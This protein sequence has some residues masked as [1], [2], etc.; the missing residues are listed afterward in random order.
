M[1]RAEYCD[2]DMPIFED[3]VDYYENTTGSYLV[4][5]LAEND[6]FSFYVAN[7]YKDVSATI[8]VY[9]YTEHT[10][11]E[12][13]IPAKLPTPSTTGY[14][15][16]IE[17][18]VCGAIIKAPVEIKVTEEKHNNFKIAS[19]SLTMQENISVNYY[20]IV[21][22]EAG[23]D[24]ENAYIVFLFNGEEFIVD[25]YTVDSQGRLKFKFREMLP[26]KM[27]DRIDAYLYS[28]TADGEYSMNKVENY[29]VMQYAIN[30]INKSSTTDSEKTAMADLLVYGAKT[31]LYVGYRTDKLVTDLVA[32]QGITLNPSQLDK[33]PDSANVQS[34]TGDRTQGADWNS[35]KLVF[36]DATFVKLIFTASD[37]MVSNGLVAK[38]EVAGTTKYFDVSELPKDEKGRYVI[39]IDYIAAYQFNETITATFEI[40]EAQVGSVL[41]Y[42]INSFLYRNYDKTD[43]P[44]VETDLY[45][46]LYLYGESV[47]K[48]YA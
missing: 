28:E 46:A 19:A 8:E 32:E 23:Y 13:E 48:N 25:E 15:A 10:H 2:A 30:M 31:Q 17:C 26:Q 35:G 5:N 43:K 16:G 37:E 11:T 42:S 20:T 38:I 36:D 44:K 39:T 41:T 47:K 9:Y 34:L 14:T 29:S 4:V 1:W 21:K 22:A 33:I 27:A 12:V 7:Y 45:K 24:R 3:I 18:S 40:D 6:P